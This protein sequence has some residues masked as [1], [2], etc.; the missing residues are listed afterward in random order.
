LTAS[1][2]VYLVCAIQRIPF[3]YMRAAPKVLPPILS[4]WLKTA[5]VDVGM[6]VEVEPSH[7]YP[8]CCHMK[9]GS[10]GTV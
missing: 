7:Q 4:C 3:E 6:V 2:I 10:R 8:F 5:E 1:K 9:D